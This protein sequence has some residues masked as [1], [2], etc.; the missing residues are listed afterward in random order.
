MNYLQIRLQNFFSVV[1]KIANAVQEAY[2]PIGMNLLNN[3]GEAA[4]QT[5]FH[6]HIHIIPRYG[7]G[8]GFGMV[9]KSHQSDYSFDDLQKVAGK[10]SEKL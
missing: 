2:D 1:P 7:K 10:I 8:D 9:W 4:M 6:Y 5:V 3:N